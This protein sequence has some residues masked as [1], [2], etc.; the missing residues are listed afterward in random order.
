MINIVD[1]GIGNLKSIFNILNYIGVDS[2]IS[3][4]I[5]HIKYSDKLILPGVG[6]FN[7]GMENLRNSNLIES[8]NEA[9][10]VRKKPI[11]GICLGMQLMTNFSEEG[12]CEGL[13]W[14]DATT[15]KIQIDSSLKVP[16]MGWNEVQFTKSSPLISEDFQNPRFYFVHSYHVVCNLK[17]DLLCTTQYGIELT[18]GFQHDHIFGVQFHPEKSHKYGMELLKKFNKI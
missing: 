17:D 15:R 11:L 1:Y 6:H 13:K 2:R 16:H 12:D 14:I 8:L 10:I 7:T 4:S 3:N 9:V 5:D 18:A